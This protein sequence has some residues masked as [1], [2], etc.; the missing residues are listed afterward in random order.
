MAKTEVLQLCSI[1]TATSVATTY[2]DVPYTGTVVAV[3]FDFSG[4]AGAAVNG[5]QRC[6]VTKGTL[7]NSAVNNAKNEIASAASSH[8]I[9]GGAFGTNALVTGIAFP[10]KQGERV[11]L[12]MYVGGTA[13]A[14][15]C[16]R[17]MLH[18]AS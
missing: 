16:V 14:G 18:F 4:I 5:H 13:P 3:S 8:P 15:N 7:D 10:L 12:N 2:I 6:S 11:Y 1:A 9:S 17:A